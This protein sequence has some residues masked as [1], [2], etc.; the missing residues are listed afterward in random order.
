MKKIILGLGLLS[1]SVVL[2]SA[3]KN[4]QTKTVV[5]KSY[6]IKEIMPCEK[7]VSINTSKINKYEKLDFKSSDK[8]T[9]SVN[10]LKEGVENKYSL[11][12]TKN[13]DY[14]LSIKTTRYLKDKN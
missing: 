4:E 5:K 7:E 3:N 8:D 14:K 1:L 11:C 9:A 12:K 6:I 13:N 10:E 2:V